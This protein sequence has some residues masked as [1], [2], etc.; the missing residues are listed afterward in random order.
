MDWVESAQARESHGDGTALMGYACSVDVPQHRLRVVVVDDS[1][2]FRELLIGYLEAEEPFEV[3][4]AAGDGPEAE[5]VIDLTDPDVV[6]LDVHLP[7]VSGLDVLD[8]VRGRHP[9]MLV[10]LETCDD[11]VGVEAARLGADLYLD[12]TRPFDEVCDA[13]R[14]R[15]GT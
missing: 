12:K 1:S 10:V 8:H 14:S 11:T 15:A 13:I 4:G 7:S 5:A 2:S 6:I 9:S 3:V